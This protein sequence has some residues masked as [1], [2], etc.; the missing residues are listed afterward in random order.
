MTGIVRT[1]LCSGAALAALSGAAFGQALDLDT[2]E[3]TDSMILGPLMDEVEGEATPAPARFETV[4]VTPSY[5]EYHGSRPDASRFARSGLTAQGALPRA[6]GLSGFSAQSTTIAGDG[7]SRLSISLSG[8]VERDPLFS[9]PAPAYIEAGGMRL[10]GFGEEAPRVVGLRYETGFDAEGD[11]L[12]FGLAPRAGVR[13]GEFASGY[14][15]GATFRVGQYIREELEGRPAWWLF[16]GADREA[17][18]YNPGQRLDMRDAL[19]HSDYTMVGDAQAGLA[20]R[21]GGANVSVAYVQRETVYSIPTRSWETREDF[22]A[23]TLSWKR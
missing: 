9:G 4:T 19:A 20:M 2:S 16:A 10:T 12:D 21:L 6:A 14:E 23:F 17:V 8:D 22:A 15:A 5:V 11:S 3:Q 13:L 1:F 18:R 7:T